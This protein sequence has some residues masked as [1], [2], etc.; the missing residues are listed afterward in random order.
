MLHGSLLLFK[1]HGL[2]GSRLSACRW[3]R[4]QA[5]LHECLFCASHVRS[6]SKSTHA[7]YMPAGLALRCAPYILLCLAVVLLVRRRPEL[8]A[9]YREVIG[10]VCGAALAWMMVQLTVH[11]GLDLF[12]LHHGSAL[13]LLGAILLSSPAA[14]L[15]M[16]IM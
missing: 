14:W 13:A 9:R 10:T 8:H 4:W 7:T 6:C 12:K 1:E 15:F 16:H 5:L 2:A 11:R 3:R